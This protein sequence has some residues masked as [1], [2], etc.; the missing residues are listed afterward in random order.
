VHTSLRTAVQSWLAARGE[1]ICAAAGVASL[2]GHRDSTEVQDLAGELFRAVSLDKLTVEDLASATPD[3]RLYDLSQPAS[4]GAVDSFISHSWQDDPREKWDMLQEYR[5]QFKV[6][7]RREPLVWIDKICIDS[8]RIEDNLVCLP[9]F[10]AGCNELWAIVGNTYLQRLW[11]VIELFVFLEMGGELRQIKLGTLPCAES[12]V[13]A[14]STT[15]A[16]RS[17][18]ARE[19][20]NAEDAE[21]CANP[22]RAKRHS[23]RPPPVSMAD[24]TGCTSAWI[25]H[26]RRF[27]VSEATCLLPS[28][29]ERLLATIEASFG[30]FQTFNDTL[31]SVLVNLVQARLPSTP[32]SLM[33]SILAAQHARG[34]RRL[35][36][37][38]QQSERTITG[39]GS[40]QLY[41][42]AYSAG[43]SVW[44]ESTATVTDGKDDES[45]L[46]PT[47]TD[48]EIIT[49]SAGA[50]PIK[51]LGVVGSSSTGPG[52]DADIVE[53]AD[54]AGAF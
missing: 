10:L 40:L 38:D 16:T 51:W 47:S 27:D 4:F 43:A 6:E 12:A 46:S 2:L 52:G 32:T 53:E 48:A 39:G 11:C 29:Q 26:F 21:V 45:S 44:P 24:A 28:D 14:A 42:L 8:T 36:G 49:S 23:T 7:H 41:P 15:P 17:T 30:D 37:T 9:V 3:T 20:R 1:A 5:K 33:P 54:L 19:D 50:N 22:C 35:S 31:R 25:G 18:T 13:I 34:S